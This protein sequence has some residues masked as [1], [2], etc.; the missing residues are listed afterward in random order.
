MTRAL[1]DSGKIRRSRAPYAVFSPFRVE[2]GTCIALLQF[3]AVD[4]HVDFARRLGIF[5]SGFRL[6]ALGVERSRRTKDYF[7]ASDA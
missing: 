4:T 5:R 7:H 2:K 1:A 3:V 6:H